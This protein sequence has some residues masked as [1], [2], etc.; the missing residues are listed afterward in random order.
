MLRPQ[1]ILDLF[2]MLTVTHHGQITD[3]KLLM[4]GPH[5]AH[6]IQLRY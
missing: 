2:M 5:P 1:S 4:D 6:G 3:V